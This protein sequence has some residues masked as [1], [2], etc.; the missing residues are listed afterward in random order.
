MNYLKPYPIDAKKEYIDDLNALLMTESPMED[1]YNE[2]NAFFKE[3]ICLIENAINLFELGYFD[4]AYY[5]LREALGLAK[6]PLFFIEKKE[7]YDEWKKHTTKFCDNWVKQF[8]EKNVVFDDVRERLNSFFETTEVTEARLNKYIH[9]QGYKTFYSLRFLSDD[10]ETKDFTDEFLGHLENVISG[11]VI[12]RLVIDPMPIILMNEDIVQRM[13]E[14]ICDPFPEYLIEK[15]IN[16]DADFIEEYKKT[17]L[18]TSFH[19][20][21]IQKEK[22]IEII[23]DLKYLQKVDTTRKEDYIKQMHLLNSYEC[24]AIIIFVENDLI[25]Y[26]C[27]STGALRYSCEHSKPMLSNR[28]SRKVYSEYFFGDEVN[29]NIIFSDDKFISRIKVQKDYIYML[30]ADRLPYEEYEI[31]VALLNL[32]DELK[33]RVPKFKDEK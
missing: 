26:I 10:S 5:S 18:Y 30:H 15:Y 8:N 27:D 20:H 22:H 29:H 3:A 24:I 11:I 33:K 9:K 2:F 14:T 6:K 25:D 28:F 1:M 32:S 4:C 31:L 7:R 17:D 12:Y 23:H 16:K 13:D 21:F 19:D